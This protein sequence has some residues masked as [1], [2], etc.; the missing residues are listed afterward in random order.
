MPVKHGEEG[1][2]PRGENGIIANR[3]KEPVNRTERE[4][5]DTIHGRNELVLFSVA[6]NHR[7]PR[8]P[9]GIRCIGNCLQ[10]PIRLGALASPVSSHLVNL[11]LSDLSF[12]ECLRIVGLAA[13]YR[14]GQEE[15]TS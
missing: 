11:C 4:F 1:P 12:T 2:T 9:R 8:D 6:A 5:L 13:P 15:T 3:F 10:I 7:V 14:V